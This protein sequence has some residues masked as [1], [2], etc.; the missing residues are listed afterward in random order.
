MFE[1]R[2]IVQMNVKFLITTRGTLT[3]RK[4][5]INPN[6]IG[7]KYSLIVLVGGNFNHVSVLTSFLLK[8]I[9]TLGICYDLG[10]I[11]YGNLFY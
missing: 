3:A 2:F 7:V 5:I 6:S 8:R 11:K 10:S 4:E 9:E 1:Y